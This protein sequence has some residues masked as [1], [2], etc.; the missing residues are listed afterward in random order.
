MSDQ[1]A[2]LTT[3]AETIARNGADSV[4]ESIIRD[5]ALQDRTRFDT[6]LGKLDQGLSYAELGELDKL[7]GSCA[8]FFAERK[9]VMVARFEREIEVYANQVALLDTLS[10]SDAAAEANLEQWQALLSEERAQSQYFANL[11]TAQKNII[12]ALLDGKST[13]SDEIQTILRTVPEIRDE[14]VF[15]RQKAATIRETLTTL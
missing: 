3:I 12:D 4:T 8:S 5:C 6:L 7:F 2:V 11:V 9:A 15:S 1:R 10:L 14:L 13:Q